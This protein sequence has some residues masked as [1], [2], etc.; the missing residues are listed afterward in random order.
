MHRIRYLSSAC[1]QLPPGSKASATTQVRQR[2]LDP[3][4]RTTESIE[5]S[6]VASCFLVTAYKNLRYNQTSPLNHLLPSLSPPPSA[7]QAL[8]AHQIII[9]LYLDSYSV[10][11]PPFTPDELLNKQSPTIYSP[12]VL[13]V[14]SPFLLSRS[15]FSPSL[16]P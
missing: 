3:G 2:R 11:A 15:S 14:T 6:T 12:C 10:F 9:Y 16:S 7:V 5:T 8:A 13:R 1:S 4:E